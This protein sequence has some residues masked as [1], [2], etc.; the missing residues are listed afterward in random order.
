MRIYSL[1]LVCCSV[2]ARAVTLI[3]SETFRVS[4]HHWVQKPRFPAWTYESL[5][6][7]KVSGNGET[8]F[9]FV[10]PLS[11]RRSMCRFGTWW[12]W[13]DTWWWLCCLL[14]LANFSKSWKK[15]TLIT[16]SRYII[17]LQYVL[18]AVSVLFT[19]GKYEKV[20]GLSLPIYWYSF[21]AIFSR[22]VRSWGPPQCAH[23]AAAFCVGEERFT[24]S[25]VQL[26]CLTLTSFSAVNRH[27]WTKEVV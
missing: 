3:E 23:R 6:K 2:V 1:F 16:S 21:F 9:R 25:V 26:K 7:R 18:D 14:L 24:F 27:I 19:T 4:G 13:H 17:S 12:W 11:W 22:T 10:W 8:P 5:K 15:D 20:W